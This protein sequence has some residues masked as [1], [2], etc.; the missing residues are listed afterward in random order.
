L[1]Q[2]IWLNF[3]VDSGHLKCNAKVY[4]KNNVEPYL[5]EPNYFLLMLDVGIFHYHPS[6]NTSLCCSIS[7]VTDLFNNN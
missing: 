2:L 1:N 7:N 3:K 5:A 4:K 6:L